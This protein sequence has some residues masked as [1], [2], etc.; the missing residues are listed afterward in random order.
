MFAY[1]CPSCSQRLLA[2]EERAGQKTICPR[3]LQPLTVPQPEQVAALPFGPSPEPTAAEEFTPP[4]AEVVET[5]TPAVTE[6][7][8]VILNGPEVRPSQPQIVELNPVRA[9]TAELDRI[10]TVNMNVIAQPTTSQPVTP[11]RPILGERKGHAVLNP[12]GLF[13]VDVAAELSAAISMRMAPPPEPALDRNVALAGW[14]MGLILGLGTWV[15]G[16]FHSPAWF[17]FV[18]LVGATMIAFGFL[19]RAYL[20]GRGSGWAAGVATLLPPVCLVQLLRPIGQHGHRPL[21]FVMTGLVLGALF[22]GGPTVSAKVDSMIGMKTQSSEAVAS[23]PISPAMKLRVA[24]NKVTALTDLTAKTA[25]A[26]ERT[27]MAG[28]LTA[29]LKSDSAEARAAALTAMCEWAPGGELEPALAMLDKKAD[30]DAA[31]KVLV[32]LGSSAE[33]KLRELLA[34]KSEPMVLTACEVLEQI[35]GEQSLDDLRKLADT[36]STRAVRVEA[37]TAATTI[38]ERLNGTK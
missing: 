7:P 25:T 32:K 38:A 35:G 17:P 34:S 1:P 19:W 3:C 30:R 8:L 24:K 27:E 15:M 33:T 5:P 10:S 4:P 11:R 26:E 6:A 18:A 23:T 13:Q 12:T 14:G 16:V 20:S 2:P 28:E 36:A 22:A 31:K 21:A 9:M 37:A 29:M